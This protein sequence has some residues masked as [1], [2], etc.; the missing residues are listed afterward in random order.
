MTVDTESGFSMIL[1]YDDHGACP[2]TM[3]RC[4]DIKLQHFFYLISDDLT[5]ELTGLVGLGPYGRCVWGRNNGML[6]S[7]DGS[8]SSVSQR[9]MSLEHVS[10]LLMM[11]LGCP[12]EVGVLELV[13]T[14][15]G[16]W[17]LGPL[18]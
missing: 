9:R 18:V 11:V 3:A 10:N 2:S 5:F 17:G 7:T 15:F 12:T 6:C 1:G 4:T 14:S 16:S 13:M 8:Q